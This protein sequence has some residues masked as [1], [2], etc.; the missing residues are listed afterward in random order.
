MKI[1]NLISLLPKSYFMTSLQLD[2]VEL[3]FPSEILRRSLDQNVT[4]PKLR[5]MAYSD[6]LFVHWKN[7]IQEDTELTDGTTTVLWDVISSTTDSSKTTPPDNGDTGLAG[8][9][10]VFS[11]DILNA[12]ITDLETEFEYTFHPDIESEI[13]NFT[14]KCVFWNESGIKH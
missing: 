1:V 11:I 8:L 14:W 9:W 6:N 4:Q 3:K 10:R 13:G 12:T 5:V 7:D 2:N